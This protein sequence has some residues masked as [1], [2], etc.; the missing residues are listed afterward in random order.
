MRQA[1]HALLDLKIDIS[2]GGYFALQVLMSDHVF[3]EVH[4]LE[5]HVFVPFHGGIGVEILDVDFHVAGVLGGDSAVLMQLDGEQGDGGRAAIAWIYDAVPPHCQV[6]PVW[7]VLCWSVAHY[8]APICD[9]PPA[10][11]WDVFL[12][13]EENCIGAFD[14]STHAL[15]EV[16]EF[17]AV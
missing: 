16:P 15:S 4:K 8:D 5:P 7:F 13:D 9:I 14:S 11:G 10:V 6:C 12:V 17:V 3:R 1:V 2:V